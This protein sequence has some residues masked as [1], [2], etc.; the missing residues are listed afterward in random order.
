VRLRRTEVS[1][2][3]EVES[4][5]CGEESATASVEGEHFHESHVG[6]FLDLLI[7]SHKMN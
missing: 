4:N 6:N 1:C 2:D 3:G 7:D 5:V